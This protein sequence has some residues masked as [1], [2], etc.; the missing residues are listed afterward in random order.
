MLD[1]AAVVEATANALRLAQDMERRSG[2]VCKKINLGGGFGVAH[3]EQRRELDLS[4]LARGLLPLFAE[5]KTESPD[6]DLIFELAI[7]YGRSG[8][9]RDTSRSDQDLAASTSSS[10]TADSNHHLAAAGTF[11]AALRGNFPAYN[12]TRPDSTLVTRHIAGPSCNPT[13]LLGI[14]ARLPAPGEG[15]LIGVGMSGSYG[16]TASPLL[17]LGR[18]T[19]VELVR[20]AG[21]VLVGRRRH[22]ITDFN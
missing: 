15:D 22:T 11:G 16:L 18:P 14:D 10:A 4:A 7:H 2:L 6:C 13:D 8:T 1:P 5:R 21:Q 3:T 20:S 9:L 12:L 17:F 19:P